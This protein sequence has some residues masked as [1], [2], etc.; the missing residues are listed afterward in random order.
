MVARATL[1][2][3]ERDPEM[4]LRGLP[5]PR[6]LRKSTADGSD[7][8]VEAWVASLTEE[9]RPQAQANAR[10]CSTSRGDRKCRR[11]RLWAA[12]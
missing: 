6:W 12:R 10:S 3:V 9:Q 1:V 7:L 8:A 11:R 2:D 5:R 4:S